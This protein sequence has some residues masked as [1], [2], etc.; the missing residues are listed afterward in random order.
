MCAIKSAGV[1]YIGCLLRKTERVILKIRSVVDALALH[2]G[3]DA[4]FQAFGLPDKPARQ[5]Q[6]GGGCRASAQLKKFDTAVANSG[7]AD[8]DRFW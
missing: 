3:E 1:R 7:D 8:V 2:S 4:V 5:M 6:T